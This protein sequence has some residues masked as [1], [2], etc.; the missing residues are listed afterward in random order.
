[1]QAT[2]VFRREN[3]QWRMVHHHASPMPEV[4]DDDEE[5]TVN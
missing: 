2:N 5:D 3:E 4:G 1:M